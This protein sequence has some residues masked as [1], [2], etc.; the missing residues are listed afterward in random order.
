[1]KALPRLRAIQM[2]INVDL[3][4]VLSPGEGSG[5]SSLQTFPI[6]CLELDSLGA[7]RLLP[8]G[9]REHSYVLSTLKR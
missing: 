3:F 5:P 2:I 1:M 9:Q 8:V 7:I 4:F 6:E